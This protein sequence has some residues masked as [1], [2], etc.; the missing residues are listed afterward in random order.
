MMDVP[1]PDAD[2]AKWPLLP[3][4]GTFGDKIDENHAYAWCFAFHQ[5]KGLPEDILAGRQDLEQKWFFRYLIRTRARS[6]REIA[7]LR[8]GLCQ[9]RSRSGRATP[10]TKPFR[11]TSSTT[12]P[13]HADYARTRAGRSWIR[14]A[15]DHAGSENHQSSGL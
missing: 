7:R 2:L 3:T 12:A 15:K 1:H 4:V 8:R 5:V 10:G 11:R 9:P 6:T 14:L 13:T